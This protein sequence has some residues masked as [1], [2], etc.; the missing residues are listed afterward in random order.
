MDHIDK[1]PSIVYV[2]PLYHNYYQYRSIPLK[3]IITICG[4]Y[5]VLDKQLEELGYKGEVRL[6]Y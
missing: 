3:D 2:Q 5:E 1:T 6:V 4:W